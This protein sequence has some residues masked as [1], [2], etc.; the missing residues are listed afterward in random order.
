[1]PLVGIIDGGVNKYLLWL[2]M[3]EVKVFVCL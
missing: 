3:V 1:M 2:W